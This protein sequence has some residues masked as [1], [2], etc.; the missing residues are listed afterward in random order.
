ML[1]L[2]Q[3]KAPL[4]GSPESFY[5]ALQQLQVNATRQFL[6]LD[7]L[8]SALGLDPSLASRRWAELSGGEAQR[9]MLAI[10]LASRP[11]CL[12]LDEPTSALD[13]ASKL[14]VEE[15]LNERSEGCVVMA[16]HDLRQAERIGSSLWS[17]EATV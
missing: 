16:T 11:R 3:M 10:G 2:H 7:P 5:Q 1:Y 4:P 9:C 12:V 15:A 6:P 13:E 8:L 17:F 14:L